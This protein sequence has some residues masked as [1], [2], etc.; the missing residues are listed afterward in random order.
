MPIANRQ[1]PAGTGPATRRRGAHLTSVEGSIVAQI[2]NLLYRRFAIGRALRARARC[3]VTNG[4]Q[5]AI[6]RYSRLKICATPRAA[7]TGV[8]CARLSARLAFQL[9][10]G[11]WQLAMAPF[12]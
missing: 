9:A 3:I 1:M 11:N 10:I 8:R 6:L 7:S 5:N 12:L 4:S 2:F